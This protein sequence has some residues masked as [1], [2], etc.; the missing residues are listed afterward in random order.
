M[1][2]MRAAPLR[3]RTVVRASDPMPD[4]RH[5]PH[6]A[7]SSP[8]SHGGCAHSPIAGPA[9][10]SVPRRQAFRR[11]DPGPAPRR[12]VAARPPRSSSPLLKYGVYAIVLAALGWAGFTF[13]PS[14]VSKIQDSGNSKPPQAGPAGNGGG[15]GPLGEVNGAMDVSDALDGSSAS[16]RRPAPARQPAVA[17]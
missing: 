1:P 6:R 15:S 13:V 3:Q 14:M 10:S 8:A 2:P 17:Q 7:P 5:D 9:T 11:T 16:P 4:L 12:Q